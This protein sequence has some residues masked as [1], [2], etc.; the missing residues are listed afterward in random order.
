MDD[1]AKALVAGAT[2]SQEKLAVAAQSASSTV[3]HLAEVVKNGASSLGSNHPE[4]QVKQAEFLIPIFNA[5]V[6]G[7]TDT[8]SFIAVVF[9][10]VCCKN[11]QAVPLWTS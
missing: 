5:N 9:K 2:S 6:F 8:V 4:E 10:S 7:C 11:W 1:N 3:V